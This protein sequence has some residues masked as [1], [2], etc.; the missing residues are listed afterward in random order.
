MTS[1]WVNDVWENGQCQ[2]IHATDISYNKYKCSVF[3]GLVV[4]VSQLSVD[5]RSTVQS[6]IGQNGGSYLAPLKA[7]KTTHLVLTEPVGD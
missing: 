3:K 1:E 4:T 7:N 6:L 2:Q 5:E